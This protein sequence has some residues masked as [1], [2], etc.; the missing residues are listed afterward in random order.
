MLSKA[1]V[2]IKDMVKMHIFELN[3]SSRSV[4]WSKPFCAIPA[5]E[6]S[7]SFPQILMI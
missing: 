2:G 7:V 5:W 6:G 1:T 4:K 3:N